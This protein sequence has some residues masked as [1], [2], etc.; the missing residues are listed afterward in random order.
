GI[1]DA[2]AF[3]AAVAAGPDYVGLVFFPP[4][5]RYVTPLQAAA[6]S[7][8]HPGGPLRVGLFV[9]PTCEAIAAV[10]EA[11]R[12]DILQVYGRVDFPRLRARL[13]MPLW[14]GVGIDTVADL[15]AE[16]GGADAL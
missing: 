8:R 4:S 12:L 3:D 10:L 1:S 2:V 16:A 14:R 5:P 11:V 15:P 9:D 6:L 13:G 7:A